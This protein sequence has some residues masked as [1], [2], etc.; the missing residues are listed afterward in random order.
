MLNSQAMKFP[1]SSEL[2]RFCKD[3]F[4]YKSN[5]SRKINDQEIGKFLTF[6]PADCTHWKHGR[7]NIRSVQHLKKLS[8]VLN[9]DVSSLYDI[10]LHETDSEDN[11][12]D[13]KGYQLS[14]IDTKLREL[15]FNKAQSIIQKANINELPVF[16]PEVLEVLPNFE[17][18]EKDHLETLVRK[19][20]AENK[21]KIYFR[22]GQ[23]KP[24]TRFL[25]LFEMGKSVMLEELQSHGISI[26]SLN[27]ASEAFAFFILLPSKLIKKS[28]SLLDPSK[29]LTLQIMDAFWVSRQIANHRL[30]DLIV[31]NN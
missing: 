25:I 4:I 21:I 29:D 1:K 7:K 27:I 12:L 14:H 10:L 24:A 17:I 22:T 18:E 6:D 26:E 20:V 31:H 8:N 11:F 13:Y 23:M 5:L 15:A 19:E 3:A 16:I 30:Q 2:F 28:L 9:I